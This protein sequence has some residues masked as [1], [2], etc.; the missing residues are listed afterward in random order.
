[1]DENLK[2]EIAAT[3]AS[4]GRPTRVVTPAD[5]AEERRRVSGGE[6]VKEAEQAM[7]S[8]VVKPVTTGE[9][10]PFMGSSFDQVK[11]VLMA[12]AE[13]MTDRHGNEIVRLRLESNGD[14]VLRT[15]IAVNGEGRVPANAGKEP[16]SFMLAL[17]EKYGE[18]CFS[19]LDK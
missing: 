17:L 3:M 6:G 15:M 18:I 10:I 19:I 5:I 8:I 14:R 1:M 12:G 7:R 4:A 11:A 16:F 9:S 13:V 2:K